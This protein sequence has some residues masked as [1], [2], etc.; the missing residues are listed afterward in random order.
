GSTVTHFTAKTPGLL[1]SLL[2]STQ[3][4]A[5]MTAV[6]Q[7]HGNLASPKSCGLCALPGQ[8]CCMCCRHVPNDHQAVHMSRSCNHRETQANSYGCFSYFAKEFKQTW[9]HQAP[10]IR[11]L[12]KFRPQQLSPLPVI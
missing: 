3:Y 10:V 5:I 2:K 1:E 12:L 7:E 9:Q 4:A 6:R 11:S 8:C